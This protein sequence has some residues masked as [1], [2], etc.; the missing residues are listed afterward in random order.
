MSSSTLPPW[1]DI[2]AHIKFFGPDGTPATINGEPTDGFGEF[3]D[4]DVK[5]QIVDAL[6]DLY[7]N[8]PSA[9]GVLDEISAAQE[10][11]FF[12]TTG[13]SGAFTSKGIVGFNIDQ[14]TRTQFMGSNGKIQSDVLQDAVIHEVIHAI[15]GWDDLIDPT[16]LQSYDVPGA[17]P[18]DFNNPNFDHIGAT[19]RLATS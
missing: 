11:W 19:Q 7:E 10:L 6:A 17:P 3:K 18:I 5:K 2:V 15:Y 1:A 14:T 4:A 8:S 16:T 12:A 13:G 9:R